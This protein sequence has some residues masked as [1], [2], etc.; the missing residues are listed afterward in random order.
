[1]GPT[2]ELQDG[3]TPNATKRYVAK[4]CPPLFCVDDCVAVMWGVIARGRAKAICL[5]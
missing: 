5:H 2:F 1:M 3:K 4:K